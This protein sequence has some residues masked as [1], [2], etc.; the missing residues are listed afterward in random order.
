MSP[1]L[2]S[3]SQRHVSDETASYLGHVNYIRAFSSL[4]GFASPGDKPGP[5]L[6][7]LKQEV[8]QSSTLNNDRNNRADSDQ[9][10]RSLANA[11][12]TELILNLS[13]EF[14][15]EDE[16]MR[17]ANN[18]AVVQAYY[19][20][21]H[22]TQALAVAKGFKRPE[23]H[24]ATQRL[25]ADFWIKTRSKL[26]P[27]S[28]GYG[29]AGCVNLPDG[30]ET[31][32]SINA[33]SRCTTETRWS[34]ASQALRTTREDAVRKAIKSRREAQQSQFRKSWSEEEK[35][36]LA[37]GRKPRVTPNF[38]LP[39][40]APSERRETESKVRP[41]GMIDYLYRLRIKTNYVDS[42]MFTDGPRDQDSARSVHQDL[43][44]L[45]MS[46]MLVTELHISPLVGASVLQLWADQWIASN[47]VTGKNLGLTLRR[48]LL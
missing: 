32:T 13:G 17:L 41:Y 34:L 6:A 25:F 8:V 27:W 3:P 23:T 11:W 1:I 39:R 48:S 29:D 19:V 37:S 36:R 26:V 30:T 16:L 40:L 10:R 12:G 7:Q 22:A 43:Q 47:S 31:D 20:L 24:P 35:G 18:W 5:S 44:N 2:T 45:V 21:Y 46:T 9:V 4:A 14:I 33:W 15:E 42:A 38:P 28:L